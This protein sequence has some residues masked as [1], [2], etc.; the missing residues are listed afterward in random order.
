MKP[1]P[2]PKNTRQVHPH[3]KKRRGWT[4]LPILILAVIGICLLLAVPFLLG[5][6]LSGQS[7]TE[8]S[9][10]PRAN[11]M[12]SPISNNPL[13]SLATAGTLDPTVFYQQTLAVIH[14]QQAQDAVLAATQMRQQQLDATATTQTQ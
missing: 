7:H 9:S 14:T 4:R 5:L 8:P 3:S 13:P 10:P 6:D 12:T 2:T 1:S 11:P